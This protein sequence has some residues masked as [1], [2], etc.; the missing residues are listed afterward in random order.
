MYVG[1]GCGVPVGDGV[2]DAEAEGLALG[3]LGD[4][5]GLADVDADGLPDGGGDALVDGLGIPVGL[6]CVGV[7]VAEPVP[8][9]VAVTTALAAL[10]APPALRRAAA[11]TAVWVGDVVPP[12]EALGVGQFCNEASVS[13]KSCGYGPPTGMQGSR[14]H[15]MPLITSLQLPGESSVAIATAAARVAPP[16][17]SASS[18]PIMV[19]VTTTAIGARSAARAPAFGLFPCRSRARD[20]ITVPLRR[21]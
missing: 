9:T 6:E 12:G 7:G 13:A 2:T 19:S 1:H 11:V 18:I 3:E 20:F 10:P 16:P 21:R 15:W 4:V 8:G 14:F 17:H 5:D